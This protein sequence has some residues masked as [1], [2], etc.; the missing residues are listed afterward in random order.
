MAGVHGSLL[1]VKRHK[2]V[3]LNIRFLLRMESGQ[4]E[5]FFIFMAHRKLSALA[6]LLGPS[7]IFLFCCCFSTISQREQYKEMEMKQKT[8]LLG[9]NDHWRLLLFIY[10]GGCFK[11]TDSQAL[12]QIPWIS[13]RGGV[14]PGTCIFK[15]T[16]NACSV[17]LSSNAV[18]SLD[19]LF[20]EH[21]AGFNKTN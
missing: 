13:Q 6:L 19:L 3:L 8:N 16:S 1:L 9:Q 21:Y 17:V 18:R 4:G 7:R 11:N 15:H 20:S 5:V 14:S 10:F 2:A 12:V